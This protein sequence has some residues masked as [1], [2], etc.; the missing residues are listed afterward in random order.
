[1]N[2]SAAAWKL[3]SSSA[4]HR[5]QWLRGPVRTGTIEVLLS[6]TEATPV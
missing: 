6:S 4:L 2:A 5:S 3:E 1:M